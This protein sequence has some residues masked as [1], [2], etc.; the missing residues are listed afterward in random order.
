ML[1]LRVYCVRDQCGGRPGV[2]TEFEKP[3]NRCLPRPPG[4]RGEVPG[5]HH[6]QSREHWTELYPG[7]DP[8]NS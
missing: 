2:S 3:D 7:T 1:H 5:Q 4:P 8:V 6:K